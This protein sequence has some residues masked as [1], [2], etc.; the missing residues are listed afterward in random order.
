VVSGNSR[1]GI[2]V[3]GS[4]HRFYRNGI[5]ETGTGTPLP[6]GSDGVRIAG[7]T[8]IEIGTMINPDLSGDRISFNGGHGLVIESST[9]VSVQRSAFF[10]NGGNGITVLPSATSV[11]IRAGGFDGN[12]GLA[13]DLGDD[14]V[15]PNDALDADAGPNA[16]QNFPI[17][18]SAIT[19]VFETI[20][21]GTLHSTPLTQFVVEAYFTASPDPSGHGEGAAI[22]TTSVTTDAA[23]NAQFSFNAGAAPA[24]SFITATA[25]TTAAD[26]STSEFSPAIPSIAAEP[27]V[28]QFSSAI[29]NVN[30]AGGTATITVTR[31]GNPNVTAFATLTTSNGTATA[32]A[33]YESVSGTFFFGAGETT[34]TLMI[35]ITNDALVEGAET[36]LL[37]L[38]NPGG[39]TLGPQST[40]MLIIADDEAS[41]GI[42]TLSEWSLM[43]LAAML[44]LLAATK[45]RITT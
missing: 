12:G 6:N 13:I 32:G 30:E 23:G 24:G 19:G 44:A 22:G 34:H 33:D 15:T 27:S 25:S 8:D 20:V 2:T 41:A 4:G 35:P 42:P 17:L 11:E 14:G 16:L 7:A 31:T 21:T 28:I 5:G 37:T 1:Y 43:A 9:N 36:V 39:G 40:A 18:T 29:F 26:P 45:L 10:E 38:S 3:T